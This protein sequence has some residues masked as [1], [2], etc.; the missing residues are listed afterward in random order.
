MIG[1][2]GIE[3]R[4][5]HYPVE[6]KPHIFSNLERLLLKLSVAFDRWRDTL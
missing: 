6:E 3:S 4:T 5:A 1:S 2:S